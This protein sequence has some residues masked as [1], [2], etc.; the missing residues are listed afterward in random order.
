[1]DPGSWIPD[2]GSR[3]LDPGSWIPDLGSRILDP[4]SQTHIFESEVT[5]FWGKKFYN[6]L[7]I[8]PN[9]FLQHFKNKIIYSSVKFVAI[10]K[11]R[12]FCKKLEHFGRYRG[13]V[14]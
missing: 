1:L 9:I 8:G 5:I 12:T 10:K 14:T 2:L 6:S 3:I 13:K 4:G 7:K 11:L